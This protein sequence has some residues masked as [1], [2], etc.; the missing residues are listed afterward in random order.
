MGVAV[1]DA[2]GAEFRMTGHGREQCNGNG[3][4]VRGRWLDNLR[5]GSGVRRHGVDTTV[6]GRCRDLVST[7]VAMDSGMELVRIVME[8]NQVV[9]SAEGAAGACKALKQ[10][11]AAVAESVRIRVEILPWHAGTGVRQG[12]A[13]MET[14]RWC[15]TRRRGGGCTGVQ[16]AAKLS[17]MAV[18]SEDDAGHGVA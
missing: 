10:D 2:I 3:D 5:T 7:G 13:T 9:G 17:G 4:A 8:D 12:G 11:T 6:N 18:D 15:E 14:Q 1:I 16:S